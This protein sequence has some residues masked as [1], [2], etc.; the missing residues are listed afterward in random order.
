MRRGNPNGRKPSHSPNAAPVAVWHL[1]QNCSRRS[2]GAAS[3]SYHSKCKRKLVA[4]FQMGAGTQPAKTCFDE[5]SI[6]DSPLH[7][8]VLLHLAT[9]NVKALDLSQASKVLTD[10]WTRGSATWYCRDSV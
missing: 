4:D 2:L 10:P 5:A 9:L 8:I 6:M 1:K 3:Y 7:P